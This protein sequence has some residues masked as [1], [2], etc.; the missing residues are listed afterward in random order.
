MT[1]KTYKV[2][3]GGDEMSWNQTVMIVAQSG[4]YIKTR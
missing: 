3:F 2:S 4:E 1:P